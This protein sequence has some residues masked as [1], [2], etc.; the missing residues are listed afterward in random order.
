V[1]LPV[2]QDFLN[3]QEKPGKPAENAGLLIKEQGENI[4]F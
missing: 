1:F 3:L 4:A 2:V